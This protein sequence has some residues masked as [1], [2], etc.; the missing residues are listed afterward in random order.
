VGFRDRDLVRDIRRVKLVY[1]VMNIDMEVGYLTVVVRRINTGATPFVWEVRKDSEAVSLHVSAERY[2]NMEAAYSAG[3][4]KLPD[5][6]SKPTP[7]SIRSRRVVRDV[8]AD[9]DKEA[10]GGGDWH[11]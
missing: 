10:A 6:I 7:A 3:R 2:D 9:L 8:Y 4:A 5:F 11:R 1:I